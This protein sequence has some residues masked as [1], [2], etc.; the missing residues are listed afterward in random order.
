MTEEIDINESLEAIASERPISEVRL[1]GKT[2][3]I[4]RELNTAELLK[5]GDIMRSKEYDE[6]T[7]SALLV[8]AC[9]D[10][11]T[12]DHV[13][14]VMTWPRRFLAA[15]SQQCMTLNGMTATVHTDSKKN[16][17]KPLTEDSSSGSP[18]P[19]DD[20]TPSS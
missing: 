6:T 19:S 3:L 10:G 14:K 20:Q 1:K 4:L 2:V 9:C 18:S 11:L 15:V 8:I 13:E 17:E 16:S 5:V 7:A 12:E